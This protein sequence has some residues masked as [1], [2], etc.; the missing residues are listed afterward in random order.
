MS[1]EISGNLS[2]IDTLL[3]IGP[4]R[5]VERY[6]APTL[7][8]LS[9]LTRLVVPSL[10]RVSVRYVQFYQRARSLARSRENATKRVKI[11]VRA[12]ILRPAR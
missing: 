1:D 12:T 6:L 10:S 2:R 7:S 9:I 4:D 5:F 3:E 11:D 8:V